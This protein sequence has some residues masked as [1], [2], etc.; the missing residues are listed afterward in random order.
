MA[1]T[2]ERKVEPLSARQIA[3]TSGLLLLALCIR[4]FLAPIP[5]TDDDLYFH[6]WSH[7]SVERG[8]ATIYDFRDNQYAF[9]EI[10]AASGAPNVFPAHQ[11]FP[12][13]YLSCNYP[14]LFLYHLKAIGHIYKAVSPTFDETTGVFRALL[15]TP[16][17]LFDVLVAYIIFALLKARFS[18][19][20]ALAGLSLYAFNPA[21]IYDSGYA[22]FPEALSVPFILLSL[23]ALERE[24]PTLSWALMAVSI[25]TKAQGVVFL[26]LLLFV[27]WKRWGFKGLFRPVAAALLVSFLVFLPFFLAGRPDAPAKFFH[28]LRTREPLDLEPGWEG[29]IHQEAILCMGAHNLWWL[30]SRGRGDLSDGRALLGPLSYR[31]V[32]LILFGLS[33]LLVLYN[34]HKKPGKD[35]LF[36]AGWLIS[37]F[38]FMLPT[39]IAERYLFP[40]LPLLLLW[41][42]E[43][44]R[45]RRLYFLLSATFFLNLY[46]VFY[47]LPIWPWKA[48]GGLSS[49]PVTA[50]LW[51]SP[52]KERMLS[53]SIALI[54]LNI[55]ARVTLSLCGKFHLNYKR[56]IKIALFMLNA[57]IILVIIIPHKMKPEEEAAVFL[58][59]GRFYLNQGWAGLAIGELE[60][61]ISKDPTLS[62]ARYFLAVA[63]AAAGEKE[64][65]VSILQDL[66]RREPEHRPARDLLRRLEGRP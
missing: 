37:F 22:G 11:L 58:G 2:S 19:R 16:T 52:F 62:D 55:L 38:F 57:V 24:K 60:M 53:L 42:I 40:A 39:Q 26:P 15:K 13:P 50:A 12:D 36:R 33:Y 63:W 66:L 17:I 5:S 6:T 1:G 29:W 61:A 34:L 47:F 46:L 3:A 32:G 56:L 20:T 45:A 18:F 64:R 54:N 49:L 4:L 65:A 25:W 9:R 43:K 27:T 59:R 31:Q 51:V 28:Q 14:P 41:G 30:V 35:A 48:L 8:I 23:V 21:I 44:R 10:L 7:L